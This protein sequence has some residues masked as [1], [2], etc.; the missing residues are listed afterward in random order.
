[1]RNSDFHKRVQIFTNEFRFERRSSDFHE[2]T[3]F[4]MKIASARVSCHQNGLS[5]GPQTPEYEPKA[6]EHCK[7]ATK[8]TLRPQILAFRL[9]K[10]TQPRPQTSE[11]E[12]QASEPC[13]TAAKMALRP[14]ILAPWLRDFPKLVN[15]LTL[16]R[17]MY[18]HINRNLG[19]EH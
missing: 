7:T 1:M 18:S 14:Q 5:Q 16:P 17:Y 8:L 3:P 15:V 6:S 13:K 11:Y 19:P 10:W 4:H 12:P 2:N 9:P